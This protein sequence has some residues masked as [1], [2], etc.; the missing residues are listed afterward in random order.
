MQLLGK[1]KEN[2]YVF[3]LFDKTTEFSV[4]LSTLKLAHSQ[5]LPDFEPGKMIIFFFSEM[6]LCVM[7]QEVLKI[8]KP[9]PNPPQWDCH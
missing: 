3:F 5:Y 4:N 6:S 2:V 8:C 7:I 1:Y 9:S